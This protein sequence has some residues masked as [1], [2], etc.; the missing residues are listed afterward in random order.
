MSI[1]MTFRAL[2]QHIYTNGDG[3]IIHG[4][5]AL[6]DGACM[7]MHRSYDN[8]MIMD[9]HEFNKVLLVSKIHHCI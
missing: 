1:A 8:I 2:P 4:V 9:H 3:V 7:V 5:T 6:I